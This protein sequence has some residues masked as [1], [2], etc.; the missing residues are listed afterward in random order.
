MTYTGIESKRG[1]IIYSLR[2]TTTQCNIL[3]NS[4]PVKVILKNKLKRSKFIYSFLSLFPR[5]W[6]CYRAPPNAH[7][8]S[9]WMNKWTQNIH[10]FFSNTTMISWKWTQLGLWCQHVPLTIHFYPTG[11][12]EYQLEEKSPVTCNYKISFSNMQMLVVKANKK[13][14]RKWEVHEMCLYMGRHINLLKSVEILCLAS[15]M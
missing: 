8:L 6:S 9:A 5:H 12:L 13:T 7:L 15:T 1:S 3:N 2:C 10:A 11:D 14:T 4:T